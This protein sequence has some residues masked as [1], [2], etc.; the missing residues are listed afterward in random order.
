M[1][2]RQT[3]L[4]GVREKVTRRENCTALSLGLVNTA[5][6][7]P[8]LYTLSQK[9]V[10]FTDIESYLMQF[11]QQWNEII[12]FRGVTA[13]EVQHC[14]VS[15]QFFTNRT[16]IFVANS[17]SVHDFWKFQFK[18]GLNL[19]NF[20]WVIQLYMYVSQVKHLCY[21]GVDPDRFISVTFK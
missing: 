2:F 7:H 15:R 14:V 8:L 1:N 17:M 4:C 19:M 13:N 3:S 10:S 9:Y 21:L 20:V 16:S 12:T 5:A 11:K 6:N 18:C